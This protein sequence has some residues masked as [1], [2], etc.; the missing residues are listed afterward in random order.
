VG[1]GLFVGQRSAKVGRSFVQDVRS[2]FRSYCRSARLGQG[3]SCDNEAISVSF[4]C[5]DSFGLPSA[6]FRIVATLH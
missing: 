6:P 4:G 2:K 1:M 3:Q 5:C